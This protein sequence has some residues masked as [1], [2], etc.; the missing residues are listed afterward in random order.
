MAEGKQLANLKPNSLWE[1]YH[2]HYRTT[3][4]LYM[5]VWMVP[6]T[7]HSSR[8]QSI[9]AGIMNLLAIIAFANTA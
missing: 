9:K 7:A 2:T 5:L 4:L 3:R 6:S 1:L 8:Q